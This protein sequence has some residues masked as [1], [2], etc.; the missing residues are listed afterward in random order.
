MIRS[1]AL[2]LFSSAFLVG[3]C[4]AARSAGSDY[5]K[6]LQ[7]KKQ[8]EQMTGVK[9]AAPEPAQGPPASNTL[10]LDAP[11]RKAGWWEFAA[12]TQSGT[13]IGKQNL[14]IGEASE[15]VYSAFDQ[16]TG[17]AMTGIP[18]TKRDFQQTADGWDFETTCSQ[19]NLPGM[20]DLTM[21]RR[22]SIRSAPDRHVGRNDHGGY[23]PGG[24][25]GALSRRTEGRRSRRRKWR[26][27]RQHDCA[28]AR[29]SEQI[30]F[31][32]PNPLLSPDQGRR[33]DRRAPS[34]RP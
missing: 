31:A 21:R 14:C 19:G 6:A 34:D 9:D 27:P 32:A 1:I 24:V 5:S 12:V 30:K 20:G 28:I 18:C 16:I 7:Q 23:N 22:H 25:E 17:E 33:N 15:K 2:L 4:S 10:H 13:A 29:A 26:P 11:M 8:I 3:L